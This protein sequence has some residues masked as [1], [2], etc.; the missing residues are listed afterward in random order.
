MKQ[1]FYALALIVLTLI[2]HSCQ[3][4]ISSE[5]TINID[6][7]KPVTNRNRDS[8][9]IATP[10]RIDTPVTSLPPTISNEKSNFLPSWGSRFG[11]NNT[12]DK[13]LFFSMVN[14]LYSKVYIYGKIDYSYETQVTDYDGY[15]KYQVSNFGSSR[16]TINDFKRIETKNKLLLSGVQELDNINADICYLFLDQLERTLSKPASF[17]N[18]NNKI[19][20]REVV[21]FSSYADASRQLRKEKAE[22]GY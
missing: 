10:I 14:A 21:I 9:T 3:P 11:D 18:S 15:D 13:G 5:T 8:Y 17:E 16:L 12:D 20:K 1:K 19:N 22:L 2:A 7:L 6:T 4:E